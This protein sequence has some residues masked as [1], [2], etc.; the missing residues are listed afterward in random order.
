[1][2]LVSPL[3]FDPVTAIQIEASSRLADAPPGMLQPYQQEALAAGLQEYREAMRYSLDFSAAAHNLGNLS[4]CLGDSFEAERYYR[5]S[6]EIDDFFAPA[7]ANLALLL[8]ASG[9]NAEAEQL[10]REVLEAYPDQAEVAY[11]L[12]LLLAEMSRIE[13]ATEYL[14]RASEGQPDRARVHYN[15][16]LALQAVGRLDD[17]EA[18]LLKALSVEPENPDLLFALGDHYFRRGMPAQALEMA[19]R[20]LAA[21]PGHPQG[22]QL[23]AAAEQVLGR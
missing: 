3:L 23:K 16:G 17:A 18:A 2:E 7:K 20:L 19:D 5:I 8:N 9:R 10:L 1:M 13:E 4:S 15:Y 6:V 22:Q 14:G 21:S 11:N 12:G